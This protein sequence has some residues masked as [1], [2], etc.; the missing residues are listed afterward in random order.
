MNPTASRMFVSATA[1]GAATAAAP[2]PAP[3]PAV[4]T[5]SPALMTHVLISYIPFIPL[6][7]NAPV[8]N[9]LAGTL[10]EDRTDTSIRWYMP[11]Y[12]LADTPDAFFSFAATQTGESDNHGN[13]INK[14]TLKL[15]LKKILQADAV[16]F[17]GANPTIQ[18]REV[19]VHISSV[20][21]TTTA[22]D[23]G[24]GQ[25]VQSSYTGTA[26]AAPD[27]SL[28][29]TFDNL[30]GSVAV[31][32]YQNL[33]AAGGAQVA[34][35]G[36]CD[37]VFR[38]VQNGPPPPPPG[39]VRLPPEVFIRREAPGMMMSSPGVAAVRASMAFRRV[40]PATTGAAQT[41]FTPGTIPYSASQQLGTQFAANVYQ[42]KFTIA[43]PAGS[44]PILSGDDLKSFNLP[45]TE[46]EELKSLGDLSSRYPSLSRAYLGV[47]RGE[48]VVIPQRYTVLRGK[49]GCAAACMALLD[50]SPS[51]ASKCKFEFTFNIGPDV[52]PVD[53]LQLTEEI[54]QDPKL[55]GYGVTVP[56]FLSNR[57]PATLATVFQSSFRYS[58][59][60]EPHVFTLSIEL[61]DEDL[62][63]P[64]VNNA[65]LL[66]AALAVS[67]Q[68]FLTGS[69]GLEL[70]DNFPNPV[71]ST[72]VLNF[73]DT[74][75]SDDLSF[76][77]DEASSTIQLT[78][79]SPLDLTISRCALALAQGVS[80]VPLNTKLA[81]GQ[82]TTIPLPP[83]HAGLAFAADAELA[84]P[85][86]MTKTDLHQYLMIAVQDVADTKF[87]ISINASGVDFDG[88]G[89]DQIQ[90][91]LTFPSI[92]ELAPA[93]LSLNK[94][95][96]SDGSMVMVPIEVAITEL[97]GTAQFTVQFKDTTKPN[98]QFTKQND[99][100]SQALLVVQ[101][102]DLPVA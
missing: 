73:S 76:S 100:C 21:L 26:S 11:G 102:S 40:G 75:G 93:P 101:D 70:D 91:H 92:P 22:R 20:T 82:T 98:V 71:Q 2:Q 59:A 87:E 39:P 67:K 37:V 42:L 25:A 32:L 97:I 53:M 94:L 34:L 66:L 72:V 33:T 18:L 41:T 24:T 1:M 7:Q 10:M 83:D 16:A 74:C 65:N 19:P 35:T 29:L 84:I 86:P 3:S 95:H 51:A 27:G 90:A 36:S 13:P 96:T 45:Q 68:P 57:P 99:F 15:S 81:A 9:T 55:K 46:F 14:V 12:V 43:G 38:H 89:I 47:V 48:I 69:I 8:G 54:A 6:P 62:D 23:A 56:S 77:V 61:R 44:R 64:A 58:S 30:L 52:N 17:Q 80:V 4:R 88:H 50:S 5:L 60:S 63:S 28:Q 31:I 49:D 79:R 85:A 78:N